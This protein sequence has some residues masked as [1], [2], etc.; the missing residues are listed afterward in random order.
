M[1]LSFL[2]VESLDPRDVVLRQADLTLVSSVE[3]RHQCLV[4]LGVGESEAVA[5]LV[6]LS[7]VDVL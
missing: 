6:S 4:L 1:F 2:P 7:E 5:E 3:R